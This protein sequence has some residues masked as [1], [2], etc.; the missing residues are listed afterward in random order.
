MIFSIIILFFDH[1]IELLT[2]QGRKWFIVMEWKSREF[3]FSIE[4]IRLLWSA[5]SGWKKVTQSNVSQQ[6]LTE[7]KTP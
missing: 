6:E 4:D 3:I 2:W 7:Y 1:V 5:E